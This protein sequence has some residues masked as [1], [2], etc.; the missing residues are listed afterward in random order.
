MPTA[1]NRPASVPVRRPEDRETVRPH[2]PGDPR[3]GVQ[4]RPNTAPRQPAVSILAPTPTRALR[5]PRASLR[6]RGADKPPG[7]RHGPPPLTAT[8]IIS[9]DE[10]GSMSACASSLNGAPRGGGGAR[11]FEGVTGIAC[12]DGSFVLVHDGVLGIASLREDPGQMLRSGADGGGLLLGSRSDSGPLQADK[13]LSRTENPYLCLDAVLTQCSHAVQITDGTRGGTVASTRHHHRQTQGSVVGKPFSEGIHVWS[14]LCPAKERVSIG[15]ASMV[16]IGNLSCADG[17]MP[18]WHSSLRLGPRGQWR[19]YWRT[20]CGVET[21]KEVMRSLTDPSVGQRRSLLQVLLDFCWGRVVFFCNHVCVGVVKCSSLDDPSTGSD[22]APALV[23]DHTIA[24]HLKADCEVETQYMPRGDAVHSLF[25]TGP[26]SLRAILGN[27]YVRWG[28]EDGHGTEAGLM[29]PMGAAFLPSEVPGSADARCFVADRGVLREIDINTNRSYTRYLKV[30][31]I[32]GVSEGSRQLFLCGLCIHH[33]LI[34]ATDLWNQAILAIYP[35]PKGAGGG[36]WP[37]KAVMKRCFGSAPSRDL[38][39]LVSEAWCVGVARGVHGEN[40]A[41]LCM[42]K[43]DPSAASNWAAAADVV[44][45]ASRLGLLKGLGASSR[46]ASPASPMSQAGSPSH[47][48]PMARS[49]YRPDS[50]SPGS[51]GGGSRERQPWALGP[52]SI[53]S[54]GT[55]LFVADSRRHAV[56]GWDASAPDGDPAVVCGSPGN[57]GDKEGWGMLGRLRCPNGIC[58]D[59]STLSLYVADTG[60]DRVVKVMLRWSNGRYEGCILPVELVNEAGSLGDPDEPLE[61]VRPT[62]VAFMVRPTTKYLLIAESWRRRVYQVGLMSAVAGGASASAISAP[63]ERLMDLL[64]ALKNGPAGKGDDGFQLDE[65]MTILRK[66]KNIYAAQI[67]RQGTDMDEQVAAFLKVGYVDDSVA[68]FDDDESEGSDDGPSET[69]TMGGKRLSV[70]GTLH[71]VASV[72]HS[73][74]DIRSTRALETARAV[75]QLIKDAPELKKV[76]ITN[77]ELKRLDFD[78]WAIDER[79]EMQGEAAGGTL[80]Q[81]MVNV[82][83]Q[84][85]FRKHFSIQSSQLMAFFR[86]MQAGYHDNPYHNAQH[87]ADVLQTV[88]A[89]LQTTHLDR[90]LSEVEVLALLFAAAIHDFDHPGVSNQFLINTKDPLALTYNDQA[91]LEN[92][93]VSK[94]FELMCTHPELDWT[95]GMSPHERSVLRELVIFLVL[96]TDMKT[97]FTLLSTFKTRI[98]LLFEGV[99]IPPRETDVPRISRTR[100]Q[101][102]RGKP[103]RR[104]SADN[105]ERR[106]S[107]AVARRRSSVARS[108]T[109]TQADSR[110]PELDDEDKKCLMRTLLHSADISNPTKPHQ[111]YL[112][113]TDRV[114]R[115]FG[116]QGEEEAKAGLDYSPFCA[117][118]ADVAKCQKGFIDFVVRPQFEQLVRAF[119]VLQP[120]QV[121]MEGNYAHWNQR[122]SSKAG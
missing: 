28:Y 102:P 59:E 118:G 39:Q 32:P 92:Y 35:G 103:G 79:C 65:A 95:S 38:Q 107:G 5:H 11:E 99:V 17:S 42:G 105:R 119:P 106:P 75:R 111:V 108:G 1:N 45:I 89:I 100:L 60:N 51:R 93:H 50:A 22:T 7:V 36:P 58:A 14:I 115:E 72:R 23:G 117:P 88:H 113:W 97:H 52:S 114:M 54:L 112:E 49:G 87:A 26:V 30:E 109:N 31:G 67:V 47:G 13:V 64:V 57:P 4:A 110:L 44:G 80:C 82:F 21:S 9:P 53:T 43:K 70:S 10:P 69:G 40:I 12:H 15:I 41:R 73:V 56:F 98:P 86:V 18:N 104:V 78:I 27:P 61:L 68:D 85:Q 66:S 84:Y 120:L 81:M 121:A 77:Y 25:P 101:Q 74:M 46:S 8:L 90:M 2:P 24:I 20:P 16:G 6:R 48:S 122:N 37:A 34:Y 33:D 19:V 29:M 63:L 116:Q 71:R 3:R 76:E 94:V 83:N 96:G 91:V 55:W 62:V